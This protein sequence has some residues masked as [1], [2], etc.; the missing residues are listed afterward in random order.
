MNRR[1]IIGMLRETKR[2]NNNKV[3]VFA[4][5]HFPFQHKR[6][7]E[8]LA[9][10]KATHKPD[11]VVCNGDLSDSYNFSQYA[12][13]MIADNLGTEMKGLRKFTAKL[14]KIFPDLIITDSNHDARLWRKAKVAG[15]PREFLIPY[16][17]M[18]GAE[19]YEGWQLVEDFRFTV[20]ADRSKWQVSHW[21]TGS[22][23]GT[24]MK[25]GRNVV[26]SHHHTRQGCTRWSPEK[27]KTLWS[28]DTG[29]LIDHKSYAFAYAKANALVQ[30]C[31]AV[32]IEEGIPRVLPL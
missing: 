1:G 21:K 17:K 29:C 28:V 24:S 9:D 18:I 4:D 23:Q 13:D 26:L 30:V 16:M 8:F 6:T 31:G 20:D 3:L 19:S 2:Y 27:G 14:H 11:R 7:F 5:Q 32:I 22:A 10:I 12:K 25:L 15:I